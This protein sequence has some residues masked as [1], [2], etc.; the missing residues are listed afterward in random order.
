MSIE[1]MIKELPEESRREVEEFVRSLLEKKARKKRG[2]PKF[3]W[4]GALK[5]LKD[6]YTSVE[7]QHKASEWRTEDL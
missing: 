7:L 2:K 3:D 5:D 6:Q 1:E 4:E